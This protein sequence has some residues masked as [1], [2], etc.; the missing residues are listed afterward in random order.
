MGW[1]HFSSV[2][3]G[4]NHEAPI[5]CRYWSSRNW[6]AFNRK[7]SISNPELVEVRRNEP[8][9]LNPCRLY[10]ELCNAGLNQNWPH[11]PCPTK[12]AP[13]SLSLHPSA[14]SFAILLPCNR[15]VHP[16]RLLL[17][18]AQ[19]IRSAGLRALDV[20]ICLSADGPELRRVEVCG[21]P[22]YH[23]MCSAQIVDITPIKHHYSPMSGTPETS[24]VQDRL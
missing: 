21:N 9:T 14:A 19:P 5:G 16:R 23:S 24:Q 12:S 1:T 4:N 8:Q 22:A 6:V 17:Q 7:K 18:A 3:W 15:N 13:T 20:A 10:P 11:F 2:I